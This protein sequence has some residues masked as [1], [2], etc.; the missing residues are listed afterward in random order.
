MRQAPEVALTATKH[1]RLNLAC[2][3]LGVRKNQLLLGHAGDQTVDY[4]LQKVSQLPEAQSMTAMPR[5]LEVV[6][7]KALF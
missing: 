4:L 3:L 6:Q 5:P 2:W 1:P 7:R